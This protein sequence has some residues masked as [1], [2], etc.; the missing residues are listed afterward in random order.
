MATHSS[1][2]AWRIPGTEEPGG[3]LSMGSNR[4]R[5]DW[6]DLA[7]AA[8]EKAITFRYDCFLYAWID[9]VNPGCSIKLDFLI[10]PIY[11]PLQIWEFV[12]K[13]MQYN[14][15]P[16]QLEINKAK[17]KK[18]KWEGKVIILVYIGWRKLVS[19]HMW[20]YFSRHTSK[21][22][23]LALMGLKFWWKEADHKLNK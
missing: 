17:V 23:V 22:V 13:P 2:L 11:F 14:L 4:V 7:G 8:A 20:Q 15:N 3:Q 18:K 9:C 19:L 1:V 10:Y 12:K 5:H 6:S 16:L 21:I